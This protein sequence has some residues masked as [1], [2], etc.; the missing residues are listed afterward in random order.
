MEQNS[1]LRERKKERTREQLVVAGCDLFMERGYEETSVEDIVDVVCIS[2]RTFFRYFQ[3]KDDVLV[4]W[5]DVFAARVQQ[6]LESR[7]VAEAP[8]VA[9]E[10]ALVDVVAA[11][12]AEHPKLFAM[13]RMI[14]RTP[15]VL[16][17]K[18]VRLHR[19]AEMMSKVLTKRLRD[20]G[21]RDE[22]P[23]I[24]ARCGIGILEAAAAR[25]KLQA[26]RV[27]LA[28]ILEKCFQHVSLEV[29]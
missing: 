11:L 2:K 22:A 1:G 28:K 27:S 26:G 10:R 23:E 13:E 5:V 3:S 4:A 17:K 12:E 18:L 19:C 20:S 9:I 16:E 8:M 14:A 7:P 15:A 6:A 24:F 21:Q 25:W 29:S